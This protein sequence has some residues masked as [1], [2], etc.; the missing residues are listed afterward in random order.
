M[1]WPF[2]LA[3]G[4][5]SSRCSTRSRDTRLGWACETTTVLLVIVTKY[6]LV[7]NANTRKDRSNILT[8]LDRYS[9]KKKKTFK[10]VLCKSFRGFSWKKSIFLRHN[11]RRDSGTPSIGAFVSRQYAH[12]FRNPSRWLRVQI[13]LFGTML[14]NVHLCVN[15]Y[16]KHVFI[17]VI[18]DHYLSFF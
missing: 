6:R 8:F 2:R 3:I 14:H 16:R 17:P 7:R 5:C 10:I 12:K 18:R 9:S 11:T 1:L 13:S 4:W 15:R